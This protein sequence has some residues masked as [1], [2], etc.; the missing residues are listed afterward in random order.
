MSLVVGDNVAVGCI[1]DSCMECEMCKEGKEPFCLKG[2]S[3]HTYNTMKKYGH[4]SG[5]P[6]V[7][8][9]G[10]YSGSHVCHE[11][12]IVKVPERIPLDKVGP[13]M[14]SGITLFDPLVHWGA[15]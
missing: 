5:N 13:I 3:L 11:H 9:F 14:C 15:Y 1:I 2:G 10:G 12:F 6:D 8:N 4:V 7:Q